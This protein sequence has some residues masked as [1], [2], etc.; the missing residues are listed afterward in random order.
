MGDPA[1]P[2]AGKEIQGLFQK[3]APAQ[4]MEA[5]AP[6]GFEHDALVPGHGNA[7]QFSLAFATWRNVKGGKVI[8]LFRKTKGRKKIIAL[9]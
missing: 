1:S 6:H 4:P 8:A 2:P 5:R 7:E 9:G 3:G